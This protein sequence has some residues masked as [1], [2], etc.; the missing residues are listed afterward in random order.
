MAVVRDPTLFVFRNQ[1]LTGKF[2]PQAP[3]DEPASTLLARIRSARETASPSARE[4]T[5]K[6][7]GNEK[8]RRRH[9]KTQNGN[10]IHPPPPVYVSRRTH[11]V[12]GYHL[13]WTA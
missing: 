10:S 9:E 4:T 6:G 5:S 3:A 11:M 2:V 8:G 12:V 7:A 1:S 13:I